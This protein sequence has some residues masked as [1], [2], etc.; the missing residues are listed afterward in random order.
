MITSTV[1]DAL[2]GLRFATVA[3][4]RQLSRPRIFATLVAIVILVAV[5][6]FVAV[7]VAVTVGVEVA[8]A[9]TVVVVKMGLM[10]WY[11]FTD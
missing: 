9:V 7:A 10:V 1:R 5:A 11:H 3:S 4:A 6:V 2:R 8:V